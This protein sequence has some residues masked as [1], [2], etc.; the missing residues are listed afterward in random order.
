MIAEYL[1]ADLAGSAGPLSKRTR[2]LAK[3]Y[4][5]LKVLEGCVEACEVLAEEMGADSYEDPIHGHINECLVAC[6]QLLGAH[7]RQSCYTLQY[8]ELCAVAC[9]NLAEVCELAPARTA[10][11][12]AQ[13]CHDCISI[14]RDDFTRTLSN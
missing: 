2:N 11:Q 8:A 6:E 4:T 1:S 12:C 13:R 7:V 14:I 9:A 3:A 10:L 5:T